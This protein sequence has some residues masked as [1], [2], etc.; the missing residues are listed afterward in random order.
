M[1]H[2]ATRLAL[3]A[4]VLVLGAGMSAAFFGKRPG[5]LGFEY[6]S[7]PLAP[8]VK[9]VAVNGQVYGRNDIS[10]RST[11]G[12]VPYRGPF[13]R[14]LTVE[15]TWFEVLDRTAW[16]IVF[17]ID[18]GALSTFGDAADHARLKVLL[19]PGADVR[20]TTPN[21][22]RLRLIGL[23]RQHEI[24]PEQDVP[25]ILADLCATAVALDDP[26]VARLV[27]VASRDSLGPALENRENSIRHG[28]KGGSRCA[29]DADTD[30]WLE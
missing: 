9:H 13:S 12:E 16:R 24:T 3:A 22:D 26:V 6:M 20:A 14:T 18:A 15:A 8:A 28:R 7:H 30:D 11:T 19:G 25:V 23:G 27:E 4:L 5:V 21:P 17:D 2:A 10:S 29:G 1:R